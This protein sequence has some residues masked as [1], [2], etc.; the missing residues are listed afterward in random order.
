M[1]LISNFS[2]IG[3]RAS[4]PL[5]LNNRSSRNERAHPFC[6]IDQHSTGNGNC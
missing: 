2:L 4:C 6:A 5:D 1:N 3:V